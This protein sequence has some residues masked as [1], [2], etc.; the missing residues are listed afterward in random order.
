MVTVRSIGDRK[1][2]STTTAK[3]VT[4]NERTEEPLTRRRG[5]ASST[6]SMTG[7]GGAPMTFGSAAI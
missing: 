6:P 5:R 2:A 7:I 1:A 3:K 4:P